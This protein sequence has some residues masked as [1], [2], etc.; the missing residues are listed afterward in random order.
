MALFA[1]GA[2][3]TARSYEGIEKQ[4]RADL[5]NPEGQHEYRKEMTLRASNWSG[6]QLNAE[7]SAEQFVK[8]LEKAG[9]LRLEIEYA[10]MQGNEQDAGED[11]SND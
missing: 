11:Q 5:W 6:W 9:L 1:D 3:L 2:I 8:G 4:L 7:S 10:T